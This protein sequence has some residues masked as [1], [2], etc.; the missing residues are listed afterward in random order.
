MIFIHHSL[1][2]HS[3]SL[4]PCLP[5][6][7]IFVLFFQLSVPGCEICGKFL[8]GENGRGREEG[9]GGVHSEEKGVRKEGAG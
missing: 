9:N 4:S 5:L 1:C 2:F 3:L 8:K 7:M 6:Y